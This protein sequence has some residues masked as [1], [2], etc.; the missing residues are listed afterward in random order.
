MKHLKS[1][2]LHNIA[3]KNFTETMFDMACQRKLK[4]FSFSLLNEN[5]NLPNF[6]EALS[7]F[8]SLQT[9]NLS[10]ILYGKINHTVFLSFIKKSLNL[11]TLSLDAINFNDHQ[12]KEF[13]EQINESKSLR[14]LKFSRIPL[15]TDFKLGLM[16]SFLAG[17]KKL[18]RVFLSQNMLNSLEILS[19]IFIN[20]CLKEICLT[21]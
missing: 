11:T 2:S 7:N 19:Q 3:D 10:N 8:K 18:Q 6:S 17:N 5:Q 14:T 13:L 12:F 4:F 9:L 20:K 16:N 1:L 15:D 21:Q